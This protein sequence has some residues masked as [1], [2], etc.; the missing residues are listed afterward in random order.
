[1]FQFLCTI[2]SASLV[3]IGIGLEIAGKFKPRAQIRTETITTRL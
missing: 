3:K 2:Q 1:M